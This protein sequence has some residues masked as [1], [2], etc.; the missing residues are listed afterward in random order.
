MCL[1]E[2]RKMVEVEANVEDWNYRDIVV[3]RQD[4]RLKT[5][6]RRVCSFMLYSTSTAGSL[7]VFRSNLPFMLKSVST[8]HQKPSPRSCCSQKATGA[9][10][11]GSGYLGLYGLRQK[12]NRNKVVEPYAMRDIFSESS[13]ATDKPSSYSISN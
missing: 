12:W 3:T 7:L 5:Q 2:A 4:A 8:G 13:G 9:A 10:Y 6:V 11:A 1:Q